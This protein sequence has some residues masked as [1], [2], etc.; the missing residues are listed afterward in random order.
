MYIGMV[1]YRFK[2][3]RIAEAVEVWKEHILPEAERQPGFIK[4]ELFIDEA[5]GKGFDIGYWSTQE[6]AQ[7]Y[8]DSG[9]FELLSHRM[10][11]YLKGPPK[12]EKYRLMN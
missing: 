4:A 6:D 3:K 9:T 10:K 11:E 2:I 5:S 7:R 8:E 12:R 1:F